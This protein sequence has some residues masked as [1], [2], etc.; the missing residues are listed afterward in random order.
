[1][2]TA[3]LKFILINNIQI[4]RFTEAVLKALNGEKGI[5]EPS[6]VYLDGLPGGDVIAKKVGVS[7]FSVPVELG[8]SIIFLLK[9]LF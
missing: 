1:M 2:L 4:Y 9:L 6:Y 8:V 3:N 5:I 7:Y